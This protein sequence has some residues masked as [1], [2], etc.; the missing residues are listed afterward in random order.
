VE[1]E[2]AIESTNQRPLLIVSD[3]AVTHIK[4]FDLVPG[5]AKWISPEYDLRKHP[6]EFADLSKGGK[7]YVPTESSSGAITYPNR[8]SL[9]LQ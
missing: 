6:L 1:S 9:D 7:P 3:R 5:P 4:Y 8:S 2:K